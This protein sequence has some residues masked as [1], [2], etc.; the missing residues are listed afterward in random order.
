MKIYPVGGSV[1]DILMNQDPQDYDY[2]VVGSTPGEMLLLGFEC[3]G[4]A[5]PVYLKN[6]DEYALARTEIKVGN[7]YHGFTCSFGP[8]L[9]PE[10]ANKFI[11]LGYRLDQEYPVQELIH[12]FQHITQL[13]VLSHD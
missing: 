8:G 4:A 9:N 11:A 6:G 1:R 3:V 10:L 5:F 13:D 2:V 7:G 12:V